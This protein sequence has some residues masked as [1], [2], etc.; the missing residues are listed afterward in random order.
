MTPQWSATFICPPTPERTIFP[1]STWVQSGFLSTPQTVSQYRL[2]AVS[3]FICRKTAPLKR[4]SKSWSTTPALGLGK[5]SLSDT[6]KRDLSGTQSSYHQ[7]RAIGWKCWYVFKRSLGCRDRA[8]A[9]IARPARDRGVDRARHQTTESV[10]RS[11]RTCELGSGI[12]TAILRDPVD[13]PAEDSPPLS[14]AP[15]VRWPRPGEET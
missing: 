6:R 12:A 1:S 4:E 9:T 15:R 5:F 10:H 7:P 8:L 2:H 14:R 13:S 11:G 3:S